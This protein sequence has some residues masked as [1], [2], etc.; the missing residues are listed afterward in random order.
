M[1]LN[2]GIDVGNGYTKYNGGKFASRVKKGVKSKFNK[3]PN[4]H[5]VQYKGDN[6]IV[7]DGGTFTGE[8]RY[9]SKNYLLCLLTGIAL[10][11]KEKGQESPLNVNLCVGLPVDFYGNFEEPLNNF[12]KEE[13][14]HSINVD[15]TD[16]IIDIKNSM[17][18]V[19]GAWVILE[20]T[21]DHVITIDVG[22]GTVNVIE[23]K[24][25][26]IVN[27]F[28]FTKAFY[29]MHKEISEFLNS[30]YQAGLTPDMAE[31]LVGKK[32]MYT[33]KDGE[34]DITEI[35][36]IVKTAIDNMATSIEQ[37]FPT[38]LVKKIVIFGGGVKETFKH[39]KNKFPKAEQ[40][41]EPQ[42][43]NQKVYACVC[44]TMTNE[45]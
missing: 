44:R 2:F 35:D 10:S 30:K 25:K 34:V 20:D 15:D 24:D 38:A 4:I 40:P 12:L 22:A 3:N 45:K 11:A 27:K 7:G 32:T 33:P 42:K 1:N 37:S 5:Q 26:S 31:G 21:N 6:Y 17:V 43:I 23:W 16:Y 13:T 39:W 41:E 8:D 29:S 28:T 14:L 36:D 9:T 18:F 19:E